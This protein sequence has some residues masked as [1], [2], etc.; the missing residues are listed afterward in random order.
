MRQGPCH[1]QTRL[2]G[3]SHVEQPRRCRPFVHRCQQTYSFELLFSRTTSTRPTT[4]VR[5]RRWRAFN[6]I[7][8]ERHRQAPTRKYGI[9]TRHVSTHAT[10]LTYPAFLMKFWRFLQK[11]NTQGCV[12][13]RILSGFPAPPGPSALS[14]ATVFRGSTL[15]FCNPRTMR[16]FQT[17][18]VAG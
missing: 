13:C 7:S 14:F 15:Q 18:Q 4:L 2:S 6:L 12:R 3:H 5:T 9:K 10:H 17:L 11:P 1:G 16:E 8:L